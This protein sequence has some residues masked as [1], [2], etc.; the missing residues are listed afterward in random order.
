[1]KKSYFQID[2]PEGP[3]D[4]FIKHAYQLVN[5]TDFSKDAVLIHYLGDDNYAVNFPHGNSSEESQRPYS[6]TCLSVMK[7]LKEGCK[8][9]TATN[10]YRKYVTEVPPETHLAVLQPR[11]T[12]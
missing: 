8:Y 9:S 4:K 5:S 6:R 11:N 2:T 7:S 10:V 12:R 3:T 1:M